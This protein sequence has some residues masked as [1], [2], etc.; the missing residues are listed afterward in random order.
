MTLRG[1]TLI[2]VLVPVLAVLLVM[3]TLVRNRAP[4]FE[5]P[6]LIERLGVYL[7]DNR[8]ETGPDARFPELRSRIYGL[9]VTQ[10]RESALAT[11]ESLGWTLAP[12]QR[13]PAPIRASVQSPLIGFTDDVVIILTP[14]GDGDATRVD[15][16]A[17]SRVGRGDLA[18]N[19][20]HWLG[21]VDA[22]EQRVGPPID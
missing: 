22:L 15:M 16:R 7:G 10:A 3:A 11:V 1:I 6:G 12:D 19:Q 5:P 9:P 2:I 18:A 21:F 20:S 4:L 13:E 14:A 17:A 8:I